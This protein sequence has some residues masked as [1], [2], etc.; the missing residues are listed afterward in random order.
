MTSKL[1]CLSNGHGED[2]IATS[3]AKSLLNLPQPPELRALPIVGT[4][5]SYTRAGI[6]LFGP[7]KAMPSGGFVYMDH[8]Q[9]ARDVKG[10]LLQLTLKQLHSV[11]QWANQGGHI[12]AVGDIVPLLFAWWSGATYAFVGTAKSDY[13]LRDEA[14]WLPRPY[15]A[16]RLERW[17][18]CIYLPWERWL[19][20]RSRCKAVFPR[21]SLTV[22]T[23]QQ[24]NIPAFD[25]GNP[26][27]DGLLLSGNTAPN[28]PEATPEAAA[29]SQ[30]TIV[31]LPGSRSPE[32]EQNWNLILQAVQSVLQVCSQRPVLF[33]AAIAPNLDLQ[34]FHEALKDFNWIQQQVSAP[35]ETVTA[36]PVGFTQGK[37]TLFL[38]QDAYVECLH[39]ADIAIAMAGTATEQFVGLGKPAITLAGQGPQC[40]SRF[41]EAQTR[42]LGPSV[43]ALS[44][45]H[46]AGVLI[47]DILG[48]PDR[49]HAVG[50]NGR[51]RMGT[52]GAATRIAET[53]M[54]LGM[55]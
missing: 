54:N 55:A 20:Q 27:M 23:L 30:L 29:Q 49:L 21:D 52:P 17:T 6:P 11:K 42:L 8:R 2:G 24:F 53:L 1:L 41:I 3:I 5:N 14:G 35:D 31:L 25:L 16:D 45:P 46:Q 9:L 44:E 51:R 28:R 19:M 33:L 15:W 39:H 7:T 37:G 47:Q 38:S 48:N 10:G 50:L 26:M 34:P 13:Y 40:T 43:A 12:L 18:G 4:G 36:P 22:D 32:A